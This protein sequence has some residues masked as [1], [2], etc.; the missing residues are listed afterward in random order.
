V[1]ADI[2]RTYI[3][4]VA[5]VTGSEADVSGQEYVNESF[6]STKLSEKGC[7]CIAKGCFLETKIRLVSKLGDKGIRK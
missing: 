3:P 5:R 6:H 4:I 2:L 1:R 7:N